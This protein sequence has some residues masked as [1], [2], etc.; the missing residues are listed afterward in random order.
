[1]TGW[2]RDRSDLGKIILYFKKQ[3]Y[4]GERFQTGMVGGGQ[5]DN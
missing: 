2:W 3:C 4:E 5:S 1:M